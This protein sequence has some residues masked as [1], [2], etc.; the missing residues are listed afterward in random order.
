MNI[1]ETQRKELANKTKLTAVS[2]SVSPSRQHTA[3]VMVKHDNNGKAILPVAYLDRILRDI[4]S[5]TTITVG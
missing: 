4:R 3:F 5:G 1:Q 2:V